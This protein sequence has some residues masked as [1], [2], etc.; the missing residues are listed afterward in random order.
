[1]KEL[2]S[3]FAR[4][5]ADVYKF[6]DLSRYSL[7]ERILI[8]LADWFFYA[9]AN[10][11][12]KTM[13]FETEE[14]ELA[15]RAL[16]GET[17]PILVL[18]HNRIFSCAYLWR[19]SGYVIL[20]SQSFDGEYIARFAQRLGYGAVRGS[21]TRGGARALAKLIGLMRE[22]IRAVFTV[23]GPR[24]PRYV[25]KTGACLLAKKTQNPIYPVLVEAREFWEINSWDKL[26]IPKPFTRAK[27]FIGQPIRVSPDADETELENKRLETQKVLDEL[28]SRGEQWRGGKN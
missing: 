20:V 21:S 16:P 15:E 1:M 17:L 27:V 10:L 4:K 3:K 24:G 28:T 14:L 5:N 11:I 9:L 7:K 18:W 26:Q 12:G 25:A 6:A 23:D 19:K 13:H 2:K 22:G 8:R